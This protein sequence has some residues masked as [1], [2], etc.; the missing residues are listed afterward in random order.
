MLD[1]NKYLYTAVR[2]CATNINSITVVVCRNSP[3]KA[4]CDVTRETAQLNEGGAKQAD[5]GAEGGGYK[6]CH[7]IFPKASPGRTVVLMI[8]KA[9][10]NCFILEPIIQILILVHT[11]NIRSRLEIH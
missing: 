10:F 11:S 8:V 6:P 3:K 2:L 1:P 5:D 9:V 7:A 4:V